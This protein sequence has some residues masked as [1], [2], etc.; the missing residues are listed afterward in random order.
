MIVAVHEPLNAC[1]RPYER[2]HIT[3]VVATLG[4]LGTR[5][6]AQTGA[7]ARSCSS[8]AA[9][10]GRALVPLEA[11]LGMVPHQF[12]PITVLPK[13]LWTCT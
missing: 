11:L 13:A 5:L 1:A 6:R 2:T 4:E 7:G 9:S 3:A 12:V 10:R 8:R